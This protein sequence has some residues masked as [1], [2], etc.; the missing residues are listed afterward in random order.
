MLELIDEIERRIEA[1]E[2]VALCA[3]VD[4]RGSTPQSKGAA[5]LVFANGRS[6]G[7]LGG[8][9]VEGDVRIRA[10][11]MLQG[12][13]SEPDFARRDEVADHGVFQFRLNQDFGYDDGLVCGGLMDIA[14]RL[15]RTQEDVLP[16]QQMRATLLNRSNAYYRMQTVDQTCAQRSFEIEFVPP[17]RLVIAGAGHVGA[18]TAAL[19]NSIGFETLVIDDRE[20]MLSESRFPGSKRIVGEIE[21]E[22]RSLA[23][24]A[25]TYLIV[26]TRGHRHDSAAL[27]A[28]INSSAKYIGMIGS[29]RKV[30]TV[31]DELAKQGV[32]RE[33]LLS[34]QAPIGLELGAVTPAEI[35]VSIVA[36]L[37][38]IRRGVDDHAVHSMKMSEADVTRYLDRES[39][40][41][42]DAED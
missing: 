24:D 9:C 26:V 15:L 2:A 22:L 12:S 27:G 5:M 39:L 35:A 6:L 11:K 21:H 3:V 19:A 1:G 31:L 23:I 14:I 7:T 25:Q 20:D 8:G 10:L 32:A 29:K 4:A 33:K 34:V 18:A 16:L 41:T 40:G 38:A 42:G 17:P 36:Q 30:R 13:P 28:I 37:I